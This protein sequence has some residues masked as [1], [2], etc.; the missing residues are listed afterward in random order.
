MPR[1][2]RRCFADLAMIRN[3]GIIAHID[4]GKTT[5]T[6][7]MIYYSGLIRRIGEVDRGDTVMDYLPEERERGIT[8]S[9]A[10][11]TFPW[12]SLTI[13][14]I[15]TPG[16]VDFTFEVERS[17]RVL[18][19]AVTILDGRAGVQAQTK[20]VWRQADR[21]RIPRIIFINKLDKVGAD[22]DRCIKDVEM[23]LGVTTLPLQR[24][25]VKDGSIQIADI[26]KGHL[27]NWDSNDG[28]IMT[29]SLFECS[30]EQNSLH[31]RLAQLDDQFLDLFLENQS[32]GPASVQQAIS[33]VTKE[34]KVVPILCGASFKNIGVQPLMDAIIDYLPEPSAS[35]SEALSMLAFKCVY[36]PQKGMLVYVRVYSGTFRS[37][38]PVVNRALGCQERPTKLLQVFGGEYEEVEELG[39]GSIGVLLGLKHTRTG[40][41]LQSH[42]GLI[43]KDNTADLQIP[44]AVFFCSVEPESSSQE[45]KLAQTLEIIN[46]ED[47]SLRVT[48]D[49]ESGQTL[50]AG[51]GELHLDIV[52]KRI[53]KDFKVNAEFGNV[54]I[55]Y[56]DR[57]AS[58]VSGRLSFEKEIN[59]VKCVAEVSLAI[60]PSESDDKNFVSVVFE[61]GSDGTVVQHAIKQAIESYLQY[62][63]VSR[64]PF[65]GTCVKATVHSEVSSTQ[66]ICMAIHNLFRSLL[67]EHE[68]IIERLEPVMCL[69]IECPSEYVGSVLNDLHSKRR[70]TVHMVRTDPTT[71]MQTLD[72]EAPLAELFGYA[73]YLRSVSQGNASYTLEPKGYSPT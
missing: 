41:T 46:R 61:N 23:Q 14:L 73:S 5:T 66:S 32:P 18:D 72:A 63:P 13:N 40:D 31:E 52:Q 45:T 2:G 17:I 1:I 71:G 20:T 33:R 67:T 29:N 64:N 34:R 69:Q 38:M 3:V 44:P 9:S 50:L 51:I 54:Q 48:I 65:T 15:D 21:H 19:G 27:I 12:R 39:P 47:P 11:I 59:G 55:S 43:T 7:R 8:I 24:P 26:A 28:S 58:E 30:Q 49:P 53:T 56:R 42:D 62:S 4:A 35:K 37:K 68:S 10:A 25:V 16:H 36:D 60:G 70:G 22:Y 6:E 57:P